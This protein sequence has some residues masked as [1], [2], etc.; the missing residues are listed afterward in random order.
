MKA[1]IDF[2]YEYSDLNLFQTRV[3]ILTGNYADT[4]LEYG[5]SVLA[6][7]GVSNIFT[8][9][10]ELFQI[11][12]SLAN[13]QL[14]GTKEFEMFLGNLLVDVI[15]A[16]NHDLK[17]HDKLMDAAKAGGV[18]TCKIKIDNKF[19]PEW[20]KKAKKQPIAQGLQGF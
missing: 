16:R 1:N 19:Y 20:I 17:E 4:I 12:R 3:K 13:T 6:Q 7:D 9:N 14:K 15:D 2:I 10:Y 8:F 5:G 18:D 11:P